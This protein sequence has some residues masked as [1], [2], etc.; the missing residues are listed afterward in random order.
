MGALASEV[1]DY[2]DLLSL[3]TSSAV[4]LMDCAE[5]LLHLDVAENMA[6]R[7]ILVL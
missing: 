4:L 3:R 2:V 6:V 7:I 5:S 1:N